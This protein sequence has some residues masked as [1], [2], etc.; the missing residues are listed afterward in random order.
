MERPRI[1]TRF[2]SVTATY[3]LTG[4]FGPEEKRV[5]AVMRANKK[6]I[7]SAVMAAYGFEDGTQEIVLQKDKP[8]AITLMLPSEADIKAVSVHI[9]DAGTQVELKR[10]DDVEVAIGI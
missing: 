9:L 4:F 7:G 10:L 1:T 2:F 5:K 6:D 3:S 8:N